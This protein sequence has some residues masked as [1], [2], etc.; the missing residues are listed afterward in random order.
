MASGTVPPLSLESLQINRASPVPIYHQI[1]DGLTRQIRSG[2]LSPGQL[3]PSETELSRSLGISP[4]TARQAMNGLVSQGLI[5][6]QRG[7]G[8]FVL[9]R[10][11]DHPLERMVGFTE[12]MHARG[13]QPTSHILCVAQ[14]NP[15]KE[16]LDRLPFDADATMLQIRR[17]RLANDQPVGVHD[18]YLLGV[19][20][21]RAD[22]ERVGSL[23]AL[24]AEEGI[25]LA[26]CEETIDAVSADKE[27][28]GLLGVPIGAPLLRAMRYSWRDDG[29]FV[30]Y[31][32]ALYR[33]D[34][35]QYRIRLTRT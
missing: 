21:T 4:M 27:L 9:P 2:E 5:R 6:R 33:A 19:S 32:V 7:V 24:L 15:P 35:Y 20:F 13:L 17:V 11:M 30:E 28:A 22:L 25:Q 1:M 8:S 26:D 14:A 29:E 34:L 23:Y 12:D 3:L 31:V 18:A 10:R 16:V